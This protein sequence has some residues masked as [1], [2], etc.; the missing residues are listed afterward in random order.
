MDNKYFTKSA[1]K[2]ALDCPTRLYYCCD[3]RYANQDVDNDFLQALAKGG[4]Q[5]GELAKVYYQIPDEAD[6]KSLDYDDALKQTQEL[7]KKENVN[8][9]EAAFKFGKLFVRADI[10]VKN[11]HHID[12]IEVKA[13]SWEESTHF[14]N[15]KNAVKSDILHYVYDVA[16]QKYVIEKALKELYPKESYI[17][18]AY[19]MMADKGKVAQVDGINQMFKIKD[20]NKKKFE[21]ERSKDVEKLKTDLRKVYASRGGKENLWEQVPLKIARKNYKLEIR[22]CHKSDIIEIDNFI[23]LIAADESYATYPGYEAYSGARLK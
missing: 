19:L 2:V 21:V 10:I 5:V 22:K 14:I 20:I 23:E 1:F 6:I 13:K 4:Y 7:F 9:A 15:T 3:D 17:V 18:H 11:G 16:F 8:I 12:L